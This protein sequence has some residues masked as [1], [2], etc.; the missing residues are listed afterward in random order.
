MLK[1]SLTG[2]IVTVVLVLV[3]AGFLA[4]KIDIGGTHQVIP[5]ITEG[6]DAGELIDQGATNFAEWIFDLWPW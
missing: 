2:L 3:L 6:A 1:T 5:G 4:S